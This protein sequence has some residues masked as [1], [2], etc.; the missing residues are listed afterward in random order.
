MRYLRRCLR[1]GLPMLEGFT[2]DSWTF[3]TRCLICGKYYQYDIDETGD[4]VY[5]SEISKDKYCRLKGY[6][7]KYKEH[8]KN[9]VR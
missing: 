5:L 6:K 9:S 4:I 2:F 3:Y 7:K 8:Y 1:C